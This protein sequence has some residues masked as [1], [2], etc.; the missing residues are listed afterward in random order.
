MHEGDLEHELA[1]NIKVVG[2]MSVGREDQG[3]NVKL[4]AGALPAEPRAH[5]RE[6]HVERIANDAAIWL[7]ITCV[8]N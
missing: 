5:F 8:A 1:G 3:Q 2:I 6:L 4:G 7:P